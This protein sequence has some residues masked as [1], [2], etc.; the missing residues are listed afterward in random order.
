[1]ASNQKHYL[2]ETAKFMIDEKWMGAQGHREL[3]AEMDIKLKP[4]EAYSNVLPMS[5]CCFALLVFN[6]VF[7]FMERPAKTRG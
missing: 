7:V 2:M 6:E 5:L 3:V 4:S 1:M